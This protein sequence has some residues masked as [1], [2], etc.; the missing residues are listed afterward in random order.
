VKN[1]FG[2][3]LKGI[4]I[5]FKWIGIIIAYPF[6]ALAFIFSFISTVNLGKKYIKHPQKI[7]VEVRY[8][9]VYK[10]VKMLLFLKQIKVTC[11]PMRTIPGGACLMIYNHKSNMD[12]VAMIKVF[13][14]FRL[15]YSYD[16]KFHFVAKHELS[17]HGTLFNIMALI[18]SLFIQRDNIRQN[19]GIYNKEIEYLKAKEAIVVAPEGTRVFDDTLGE[20]HAGAIKPAFDLLIP[21]LPIVINGSSGLM[22]KNKKFKK[23]RKIHIS[24]LDVQK[25]FNFHFHNPEYLS[26]QLREKMLKKYLSFKKK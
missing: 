20:F 4:G 25:P 17:K 12:A 23:G 16:F 21:I 6:V 13:Y 19:V 2:K 18:D 9:K 14:E 5:F 3:I 15:K 7:F 22:D 11:D 10:L 24:F 8:K 1:F 26:Q